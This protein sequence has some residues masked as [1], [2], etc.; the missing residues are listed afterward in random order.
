MGKTLHR[1]TPPAAPSARAAVSEAAV[2]PIEALDLAYVGCERF[3]T[4]DGIEIYHERRGA[5]GPTLTIVNNM[6]IIAPL[7]RN[8]TSTLVEEHQILTYD[9][10]NQGGSSV[11]DRELEF[12]EHVGDLRALLD[13]LEIEQTYLL[14]TSISCLICRDFTLAH[15]ERVKGLILCGPTFNPLGSKRR[16]YL[17][18]S[19]LASLENGGAAG[20]FNHFYP[21]VFGDYV[22]EHG[23]TAAYLA[24][25]ERFLAV[26]SQEQLR[27]NLTASLTT[28]DDPTKL[29]EI[30]CPTLLM[31]GDGDFLNSPSSLEG[32]TRL[33]RRAEIDVI[34][35]AGHVP[36]FDATDRFEQSV[37]RFIAN[38]EGA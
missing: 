14:G 23:G 31:S 20:I 21:L 26:N 18:K 22:I 16:K 33:L 12:G 9:L 3:R 36:Y 7:W 25:R 37:R 4:G 10:R 32:M 34:P 24:M 27:S 35:F 29:R 38:C 15:P 19:W 28:E 2:S 17:T 11:V 30:E 1:R 5:D 6:F 13:A 8:F